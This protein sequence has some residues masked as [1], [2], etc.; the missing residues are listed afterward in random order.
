MNSATAA[1]PQIVHASRGRL[2]VHLP[3][4]TGKRETHIQTGLAESA[5]VLLAQASAVTRNILLVYDH[6][7]TDEQTL[8]ARIQSLDVPTAPSTSQRASLLPA[9]TETIGKE[10]RT[11]IAVRG[12]ERNIA[13]SV[14]IVKQ[15]RQRGVRAWAKPLTGHVLVEYDQYKHVLK[16]LLAVVARVELPDLPDEDHPQHPLD[17]MPLWQG[18][19]RSVGSLIGLGILTY[20]RLAAPT[21]AP[22]GHSPAGTVAG[23]FNLVHGLPIVHRQLNSHLG[24]HTAELILDGLGIVAMTVANY[25]LGLIVSGLQAFLLVGEVTA[26]R[27]SWRRYEDNLDGASSHEPGAVVRL[28]AG[29]AVPHEAIVLEGTG[30]ALDAGGL[31]IPL[32]PNSI[33]PAGAVLSGGPFVLELQGGAP[34]DV[35]PRP[36]QPGLTYYDHYHR[37]SSWLSF[38]YVAYTALRT[39]SPLRTFEALLL[40]NR[41]TAVAGEKIAN[42]AAAART[43]R[44]GVTVIG[45]RPERVVQL[46]RMLILDGPRLL[47]DG[48]EIMDVHTSS[49]AVLPAELLAVAAIVHAAAGAPWGNAFPKAGTAVVTGGDFNG[50]WATAHVDGECYSLGPPEDVDAVPDDFL[51]RHV[52]HGGNF[53]LELRNGDA[54]TSFG[55]IGLRPRFRAGALDFIEKARQC[56]VQVKVLM[57]TASAA[58]RSVAQRAGLAGETVDAVEMIRSHQADGAVIAFVSDSADAAA[59]FAACDLAIGIGSARTGEFPARADLLT[60]DLLGVADVLEA[61]A[62]RAQAVRDGIHLSMGAN[63]IGAA[64]GMLPTQLGGERAAL[65]VYLAALAAMGAA[66]YRL[67]GGHRSGTTLA[68]LSDPRPE[69]WARRDLSDVLSA[70][71]S[72]AEG[73]T[74]AEAH[75]R[76][77][78]LGGGSGNDNFLSALRNQLTAP[79]TMVLGGGACLTLVLRQPLNTALLAFTTGL[80]VAA[81]VWQEREIGKATEAI[82]RLSVGTARVLRDGRTIACP[83]PEVVPGDVLVLGGGDRVAADARLLS[84]AGLEVNEA[85]LTGESLPVPKGPDEFTDIGRIVLEGSDVVSGTGRAVVVAVG[86]QTRLGA[87]AAALDV[88]RSPFSPLG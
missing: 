6:R 20:R 27:A 69:R 62:R 86:R 23:I 47:T 73:L 79:I 11:R 61:G 38:G 77:Q 56:G 78:K 42:L 40:L 8:L 31:P 34:F 22:V 26:R 2:R 18:L 35:G 53:L 83:T 51:A 46:P 59:P 16:D 82:K 3:A 80:N 68:H 76:R 13:Q 32:S 29:A 41:R 55:L 48:L 72:T 64:L 58:G 87:T 70:L 66:T 85:A 67:R 10:R 28:E 52:S 5:G 15:L 45:T 25:P 74:T 9:V 33:A 24:H 75:S 12:L 14:Q 1:P 65:A 30:T 63:V 7:L 57:R 19:V 37:W 39:W 4:W 43:L 49:A 21:A 54:E 71:N 44:A 84:A 88:D 50:I 60:P 81:G 17:R 36:S